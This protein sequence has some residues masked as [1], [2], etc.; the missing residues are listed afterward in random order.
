MRLYTTSIDLFASSMLAGSYAF[1]DHGDKFFNEH[2]HNEILDKIGPHPIRV[3]PIETSPLATLVDSGKLVGATLKPLDLQNELNSVDSSK[4]L[5]DG[6][7]KNTIDLQKNM[8]SID[9]GKFSGDIQKTQIDVQKVAKENKAKSDETN[10]DD[11]KAEKSD[12]TDK[13]DDAAN[14]RSQK[15]AEARQAPRRIPSCK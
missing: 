2:G 7:G 15:I 11:K 10:S 3:A 14:N 6:I 9:S 1:A 12:A 13:Q 8:K 5:G 4:P